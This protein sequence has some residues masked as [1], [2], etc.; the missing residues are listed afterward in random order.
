MV[1]EKNIPE[2][3]FPGFT[4]EWEEKKLVSL[5]KFY[6]GLTGKNKES[7]IDGNKRY[8]QYLN[9][10]NNT[11]IDDN[12][13]NYDYVKLKDNE[14]QNEVNYGDILFTQ[15]SETI[16]EVGMSAVY[17][18][19]KEIYL[20]SFSFGFRLKEI[21]KTDF[22]YLA[23]L[24]RSDKIRNR[25][26]REGQGS[27]RFNLSSNRLKNIF[28]PICDL[29]EQEKIGSFFYTI[30]QKLEL[31]KKRIEELKDYKKGMMQRIFSQEIRFKDENGQNY[32]DWEEKKLGEV[33]LEISKRKDRDDL[34]ILSS[35]IDGIYYQ[36][37]YF[38]NRIASNDTSNYKILTKNQIVFSPQNIWMGN[39]NF[40]DSIEEG[41]VSPS[42]KIFE[43]ISGVNDL[44]IKYL[45]KTPKML[46]EYK[47]SS[48]QGASVVRRN[49]NMTLF[50]NIKINLPSL[51]EQEKIASLLSGIDKK[52]ELEEERLE[53][54]EE[55]KKGLMQ[56]MF[57]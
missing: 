56:R 32:P 15:S 19:S 55:F 29:E 51:P 37:E 3:R 35:T 44:Y 48:E 5:G 57:V 46:Y 13:N 39:I 34:K 2:L 18:G 31:Q 45:I 50:K 54:Y 42:Y 53:G 41:I 36:E 38:K 20:N 11:I 30:D 23:Y 12:V 33:I 47:V 16:E 24:M 52:I 1:K 14:N 17:L 43:V 49:L 26:I 25:I 10:F 40:N 7:F 28:I 22:K 27:T 21:H 4:G 9:I 6:N 8:I